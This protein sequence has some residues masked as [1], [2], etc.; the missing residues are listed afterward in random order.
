[1]KSPARHPCEYAPIGGA[2]PS[3]WITC[4]LISVPSP[5]CAGLTTRA[6]SRPQPARRH[7]PDRLDAA[8]A[9]ADDLVRPGAACARVERV[10]AELLAQRHLRSPFGAT[11]PVL[12]GEALDHHAAVGRIRHE[13]RRTL[14]R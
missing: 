7:L 14:S 2:P 12:L 8:V 3:A 1:M 11:H 13:R 10:E 6:R 5:S 9:D 4:L